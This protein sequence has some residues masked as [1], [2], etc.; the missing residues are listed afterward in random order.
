MGALALHLEG[1]IGGGPGV[2]PFEVVE[3][4]GLGHPDTICDALAE[5]M[6]VALSK[7]YEDRF[8]F[9]LHHNV[10]KVLLSGGEARAAFGG[11]EVIA[12]I[13]IYLAGRATREFRGV[14]IPVDEIVVEAARSWL[15]THLPH[16]SVDQHVRLIP[17]IHPGSSELAALF[18]RGYSD[19]AAIPRANDTSIGVGF[20]P[21]TD[22]EEVVLGVEEALRS[23]GCL[24][25]HPYAGPDVKVMGVRS[26]EHID[27]TVAC[28][29][30]SKFVSDL[31]D[32]QNKKE[33]LRVFARDA[34]ARLTANE[35]D[36]SLNVADDVERGDIYMTVTGT[37]AEAGDDGE[38]GR[39]NRASGLITPYRP[40]TLEAAAGKNPVTHVGKLYNVLGDRI[41]A[42]TAAEIDT[43]LEVEVVLVSSIG[44]PI[45]Q[46]RAVHVLLAGR[47]LAPMSSYEPIIRAIAEDELRALPRVRTLLLE[48]RIR[49]Y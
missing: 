28:A 41:A 24:R 32:Y 16:L 3:R 36:L 14:H 25:A 23:P 49:L 40:M 1:R 15:A 37:S 19:R 44:R 30:V 46:P 27:L 42:R 29:F 31:G 5:E 17:K 11:G 8:G 43:A 13:E 18:A 45:T 26:G 33:R 34:A 39:G 38:V 7:A 4:K 9:I 10:D 35:V 12:P 48:R 47:A 20:C 2:A 22:L 21:L 6:S